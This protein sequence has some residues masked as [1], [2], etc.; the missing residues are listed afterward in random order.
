M[1]IGCDDLKTWLDYVN[2][3]ARDDEAAE[4]WIKNNTKPCPNCKAPIEKNQ[5]CMHMTCRTC[6]HEFCWLCLSN[7]RGHAGGSTCLNKKNALQRDLA[8]YNTNQTKMRTY[9]DPYTEH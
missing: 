6:K 3:G 5:G 7:Y 4:I 2:G 9:F 8:N 1:P